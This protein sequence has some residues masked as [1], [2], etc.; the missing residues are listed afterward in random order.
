MKKGD[1][2][3]DLFDT[4]DKADPGPVSA[5]AQFPSSCP[6]GLDDEDVL[7]QLTDADVCDVQSFCSVIVERRLGDRALPALELLWRKFMGYGH[8]RVVTEQKVVLETL[9]ML[10]TK[11]AHARLAGIVTGRDLPP[12]LLITAL[13][14]VQSASLKL[15]KH[16]V[17]SLLGHCEPHIR[18]LA[19][20]LSELAGPDIARL[21]ACLADPH[22]A[23]RKAAAIV[24]GKLGYD[25][26][27][28]RAILLSE[29]RRCPT[30][31]VITALS[32]IVDDDIAVHLGR[33]ADSHPEFA[34]IIM[35]ELEDMGT[36]ISRKIVRRIRA[37]PG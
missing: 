7:R 36:D 16:F 34:D 1:R 29:L 32:A 37:N 9:A 17:A 4:R 11:E 8:D 23:V 2:Q 5:A 15:P 27:E 3:F 20:S 10:D 35:I 24:T 22:Y 25:D 28:A 26:V 18:E 31:A 14:A 30:T 13:Q 33:C 12:P 21:K 19:I 6:D